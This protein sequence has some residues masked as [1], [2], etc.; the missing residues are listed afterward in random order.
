MGFHVPGSAAGQRRRSSRRRCRL[1]PGAIPLEGSEVDSALRL[2]TRS[3]IR[4]GIALG[5][6]R[7]GAAGGAAA[8]ARPGR[9]RAGRRT[10]MASAPASGSRASRCR[11]ACRTASTSSRTSRAIRILIPNR[12]RRSTRPGRRHGD[13]SRLSGDRSISKQVGADQPLRVFEREFAIGVRLTRR[14]QRSRRATLKRARRACAI[15]PATRR[16]CY[17]ADDGRRSSGRCAWCRRTRPWRAAHADVFGGSRSAAAKRRRR[18]DRPRRGRRRPP[19]ATGDADDGDRRARRLH[20]CWARPAAT[21]ARADFLEFVHNAENGVQA[22]GPV[23]GP[24]TARDPADRVPRRPRAEPDAV[25]AADDSDQPRDHRRRHAGRIA[26][27]RL[28]ARRR[29]RRRDGRRLR[30]ARPDRDPDGRHVRHDQRVAVVQPRHRRA[31]RRARAGDVRRH[32]RSTSRRF[33]SGVRVGEASRGTLRRR[34][35]DGRASPRCS[36]A[37]ASRRSSFRSCCSRAISTR[38]A[39][40]VALALP[41]LLG[42]GMAMPW[43]IAGAGIAALPKPGAWM[44]RVKQVFGVIILATAALLRLRGLRLVRQPVGRRRRGRLERRG[45]S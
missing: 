42:V 44:V 38:P 34:V 7:G 10:P 11:S 9:G 19:A 45:A 28:P 3:R 4:G 27:P 31:V 30:R 23:R 5:S 2:R 12:A 36:P 32:R 33:S 20:R 37:R 39:T 21:S 41:F 35:R 16:T 1:P 43:P 13:G 22:A 8:A 26:R 15:R 17:R 14:G 6:G 18:A 40:P 25:R 29:L 24:R